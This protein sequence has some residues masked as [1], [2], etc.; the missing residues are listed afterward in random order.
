MILIAA[1][2]KKY[3]RLFRKAGATSPSTAIIPEQ[4]GIRKTL[5]FSKMVRDGILIQV[6]DGYYLDEFKNDS[7]VSR[8]MQAVF[9]LIIGLLIILILVLVMNRRS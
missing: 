2:T 7:T 9:Y 8:R 4:H 1:K 3:K 6:N 5:V